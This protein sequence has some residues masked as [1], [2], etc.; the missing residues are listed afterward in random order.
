MNCNWPVHSFGFYIPKPHLQ[1]GREI[2]PGQ[3]QHGDIAAPIQ[4]Q[5]VHDGH[6]CDRWPDRPHALIELILGLIGGYDGPTGAI[7]DHL[8]VRL[9]GT[10][11]RLELD[12]ALL[13]KT[14]VHA[15]R[16]FHVE[17]AFVQLRDGVVGFQEGLLFV[18]LI[19]FKS[20][21]HTYYIVKNKNNS[22]S[23]ALYNEFFNK[24]T[25]SSY[26]LIKLNTDTQK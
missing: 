6:R 21:N 8:L 4:M 18:H 20:K 12:D 7:I 24:K 22:C 2:L 26:L 5:T 17:R 23:K 9:F 10:W 16:V 15:F 19:I 13:R 1:T 25:S 3:L 14:Q 11:G